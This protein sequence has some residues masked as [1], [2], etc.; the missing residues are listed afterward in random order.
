MRLS[1]LRSRDRSLGTERESGEADQST[2]YKK[3]AEFGQR[4]ED[5]K[6]FPDP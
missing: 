2:D 4:V 1:F 5:Q 6:E 3:P